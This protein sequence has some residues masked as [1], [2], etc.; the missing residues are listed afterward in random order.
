MHPSFTTLVT[1]GC[2]VA[3]V[4][5]RA[6][7]IEINGDL[8]IAHAR[9]HIDSGSSGINVAD[10]IDRAVV[11]RAVRAAETSSRNPNAEL[12]RARGNRLPA[13]WWPSE[14]LMAYAAAHGMSDSRITRE[15]EKFKNYWVAKTGAGAVKRDWEA[16]WRNWILNAME[17]SHVVTVRGDRSNHTLVLPDVR[18]PERMPSL[19]AWVAL[20]IASLK[21]NANPT[22]QPASGGKCRLCQRNDVEMPEREQVPVM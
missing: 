9:F 10:G 17:G 6:T 14:S 3:E 8:W 13:D 19:P 1:T 11:V 15:A 16:T 22:R 2:D 5:S 21:T 18:R 4:L 12:K 7:C 20:R